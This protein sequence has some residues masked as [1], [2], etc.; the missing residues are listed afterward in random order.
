MWLLS[1]V[2]KSRLLHS[3]SS[4]R[5]YMKAL[6]QTRSKGR[7]RTEDLPRSMRSCCCCCTDCLC[8]L[9]GG[10]WVARSVC[11]VCSRIYMQSFVQLQSLAFCVVVD[12]C[13]PP[14]RPSLTGAM[15]KLKA[16][17]WWVRTLITSFIT[18]WTVPASANIHTFSR[19]AHIRVVLCSAMQ[20]NAEPV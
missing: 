3:Y 18:P 5:C 2:W 6:L 7:S 15:H 19:V 13:N 20:C 12:F 4:Q 11:G 1:T 14:Q 10:S 16:Q 17:H 8:V 9:E